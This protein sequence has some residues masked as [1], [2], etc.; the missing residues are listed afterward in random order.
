MLR[1]LLINA[2][3]LKNPSIIDS[4]STEIIKPKHQLLNHSITRTNDSCVG[5]SVLYKRHMHA[6]DATVY[7]LLFPFEKSINFCDIIMHAAS[8]KGYLV[9]EKTHSDS[10]MTLSS[11]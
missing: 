11:I 4:S 3:S 8:M 9:S 1:M 6:T 7:A 2:I 10:G 5:V